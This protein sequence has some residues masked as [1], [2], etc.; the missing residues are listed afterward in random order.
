[1]AAAE[2]GARRAI[3]GLEADLSSTAHPTSV[4]L[5]Y[6]YTRL[7]AYAGSAGIALDSQIA[8]SRSTAALLSGRQGPTMQE[9]GQ[10]QRDAFDSETK[11]LVDEYTLAAAERR[12]LG[13]SSLRDMMA[14]LDMAHRD[15]TVG[16][17]AALDR[18]ISER[19]STVARE[20][21]AMR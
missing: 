15:S 2:G 13:T 17:M 4:P 9:R 11:V 10:L 21:A 8:Y 7:E 20:L 1:M 18:M 3:A 14:A 16:D 6:L 12:V 19:D 5:R